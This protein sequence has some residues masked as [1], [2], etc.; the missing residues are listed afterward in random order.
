MLAEGPR[1][2]KELSE[3]AKNQGIT[4]RTLDYAK[5]ELRIRSNRIGGSDGHFMW[6][7]PEIENKV[8]DDSDKE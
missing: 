2:A 1:K 6:E 8:I 4:E 7:L 3:E 5:K